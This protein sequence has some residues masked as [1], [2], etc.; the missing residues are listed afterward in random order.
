LLPSA[1]RFAVLRNPNV[2]DEE[3][4]AENTRSVASAKG[5]QIETVEASTSDEIDAAFASLFQKSPLLPE[6]S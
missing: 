2:R 5:W 3:S 6:D 1:T 4:I